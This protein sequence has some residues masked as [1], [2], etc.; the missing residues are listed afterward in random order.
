MGLPFKS[1]SNLTIDLMLDLVVCED[2]T[3]PTVVA[4]GDAP[5]FTI[6]DNTPGDNTAPTA[7]TED[8]TVD[9]FNGPAEVP[10]TPGDTDPNYTITIET[11]TNSDD[12]P[13]E[14]TVTNLD[15]VDTINITPDGDD[16]KTISVVSWVL[17]VIFVQILH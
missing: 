8:D 14:L 12:E 4:S 1:E 15:N 16:E 13:M 6:S 10:S 3:A 11:P 2:D 9:G 7:G 5:G 17:S